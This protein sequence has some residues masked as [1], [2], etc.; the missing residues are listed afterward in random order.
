MSTQT[1]ISTTTRLDEGTALFLAY[2]RIECGFAR[3]TLDAYAADLRGLERWMID[4]GLENWSDMR[5][6]IVSQYVVT[7]TARGLAI[8]TVAR[9]QAT[10]RHFAK[11]ADA[12]GL[13]A[14]NAADHLVQPRAWHRV[15]TLLSIR[16]VK[17]LLAAPQPDD[18]LH[19]RDVALL[20]LLYAAGLRASEA[21]DLTVAG[22]M[23]DAAQ[24]R[25][26]GKGDRE[27]V[28]PIGAPA[29]A[30][31]RRYVDELRPRLLPADKP[32]DRLLLSR[33]GQP[34]TRI[35]VSQ[36]VKRHARAA[37]LAG[38][39]PHTLRH[40]FATHLL[41]GGADLLSLQSMLG[42][43]GL[44]MLQTYAHT[45]MRQL[46]AAIRKHHPGEK[47]RPAVNV[48]PPA[49]TKRRMRSRRAAQ[50]IAAQ[51]SAAATGTGSRLLD[52]FM[53]HLIG[54]RQLS[55]HTGRAY[56]S[57]LEQFARHLLD[58]GG[59]GDIDRCIRMAD[60]STIR[61]YL[62]HLDGKGHG[63]AT[64]A[65][66]IA[67]LRS[68]YRWA[69]RLGHVTKNPTTMIRSPRQGTRLPKALTEA[70]AKKLLAMPDDRAALGARDRVALEL[71]YG[72]GLRVA[73]LVAINRG[74]VDLD[75][76]TLLVH[77]KGRKER[78][79][80]LGKHT[81]AAIERYLTLLDEL[82]HRVGPGDD[83]AGDPDAAPLIVNI[84]GD[85][86]SS[87]SVGRLLDGYAE[88]AGLDP[89]ISPHRL[90][91]SCASHLVEHGADLRSVQELLGHG[92][93]NTTTIYASLSPVKLRA[94][95]AA[96]HPRA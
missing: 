57:D 5:H 53:A 47:R 72:C 35:V 14:G 71:L 60:A 68:F 55:Q 90:R 21:A 75:A 65:R 41:H 15:P 2:C 42:H 87:R 96:A 74:D 30:A 61:G 43:A 66:K 25:V 92:D 82:P 44:K 20:E 3:G 95:Y 18:P 8:S 32:T 45:D 29:V 54:E 56:R 84:R 13:T 88:R 46:K 69:S 91:H 80:P 94:G 10:L 39:H 76:R 86:L 38:V 93:L 19:L 6:A 89:S 77:G 27:R 85:R 7:L 12:M 28:V 63:R 50:P 9:H 73:E 11:F 24:V 51:P 37:G 59:P 17:K 31:V 48:T 49:K 4:R 36:V 78:L 64:M 26:V 62:A 70:D 67:T 1:A 22:T 83:Q 52:G 16:Q 81:A 40:S 58:A 79:V 23:L 34:I 33:T